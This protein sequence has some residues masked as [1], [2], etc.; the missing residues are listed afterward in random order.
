MAFVLE[1]LLNFVIILISQLYDK[2]EFQ[3]KKAIALSWVACITCFT[4]ISYLN[5]E[6]FTASDVFLLLLWSSV[7]AV[8]CTFIILLMSFA[9]RKTN[10]STD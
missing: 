5:S 9:K 2:G 6:T 3:I 7:L 1:V 4:G 10:K 8:T